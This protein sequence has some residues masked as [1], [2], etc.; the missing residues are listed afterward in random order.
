M[1]ETE[2]MRLVR[3]YPGEPFE[4]TVLRLVSNLR[5]MQ[6]Q[7]GRTRS[8]VTKESCVRLTGELDEALS[9]Y[10]RLSGDEEVK[11]VMTGVLEGVGRDAGRGGAVVG[12]DGGGVRV[13]GGMDLRGWEFR[14]ETDRLRVIGIM[15]MV[16]R[17]RVM[18]REIV[19]G[20]GK[21]VEG[22]DALVAKVDLAL[23]DLFFGKDSMWGLGT[24]C[25]VIKKRV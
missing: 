21:V 20:G 8:R 15:R 12:G 10:A 9:V 13:M 5:F 19:S 25:K 17:M 2:L 16:W 18:Q 23:S 4:V 3:N 1:R 6:R 22:Y 11:G 14:Q 7:W 24:R